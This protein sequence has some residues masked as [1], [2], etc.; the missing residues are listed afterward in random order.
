M[1]PSLEV[2]D[3]K[4]LIGRAVHV[5][6]LAQVLGSKMEEN[7]KPTLVWLQERLLLADAGVVKLVKEHPSFLGFSLER[8]EDDL[9]DESLGKLV[10]SHPS[11]LGCGIDNDLEPTLPWLQEKEAF[12]G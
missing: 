9:D 10:Q 12:I 5:G 4:H 3:G 8:H 6:S 1:I 2:A 11:V 7:L